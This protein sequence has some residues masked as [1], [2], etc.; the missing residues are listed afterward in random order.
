[1]SSNT[2]TVTIDSDLDADLGFHSS[3]DAAKGAWIAAGR[4]HGRGADV[5]V[6]ECDPSG[7]TI[8]TVTLVKNG[9]AS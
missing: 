2:F 6:T 4:P 3:L 5:W 7:E 8:R 1:M 9:R